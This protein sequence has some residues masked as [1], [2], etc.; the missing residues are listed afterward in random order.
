MSKQSPDGSERG[1]GPR[2]GFDHVLGRELRLAYGQHGRHWRN[3]N[4]CYPVVSRRSG[5]LSIGINLNPNKACNF[6]CVYCQVDRSSSA[7]VRGVQLDRL[8]TELET[9]VDAAID[10]S[11]FG[12]PPFDCLNPSHRVIRDIAFSG[13]GEPTAY[14]R[15]AEAARIAAEVR[16]SRKL[17]D[18]KIVL[19]TDACYLAKPKVREALSVLDEN[20]GEV[21]AKLDAGTQEYFEKINRPNFPLTHVVA[22][23][24]DAARVR[25]VVVQSLWMRIRGQPPPAAEVRAFADRLNEIMAAGGRIKCVQVYT[26]ARQPAESFAAA[27]SGAELA[28]VASTIHRQ[29]PVRIETY[30]GVDG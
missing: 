26:I 3:N 13:D 11:L 7:R 16:S 12:D 15:F 25:P 17:V 19:I 24:I 23:I 8:K 14:P 21:W 9:L 30:A 28:V 20:N 18:V 27:L 2:A 1:S 10:L 4:Y 29:V 22:N 5:G 6:D